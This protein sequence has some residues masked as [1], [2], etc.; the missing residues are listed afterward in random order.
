MA[1]ADLRKEVGGLVGLC[2]EL[3]WPDPGEALRDVL[4]AVPAD[5]DDR[6]SGP[7]PQH[8]SVHLLPA[9]VGHCQIEHHGVDPF[10]VFTER[11]DRCVAAVGGSDRESAM[12]QYSLSHSA[13]HFF[14]VHQKHRAGPV[15]HRRGRLLGD[16]AH[17][18]LLRR[19]EQDAETRSLS[20]RAAQLESPA[21]PADD[22]L[23]RGQP[24]ARPVNFVVKNG[25]NIFA[26]VAASMPQPVSATSTNT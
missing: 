9:Q 3:R 6:H 19:R 20:G 22:A 11:L 17:Q 13:D 5:N 25:S 15:R 12:F 10:M 24:Q 21:M 26:W 18:T 1:G 8:F 4:F 7:D 2:Q 14:V 23:D 16:A